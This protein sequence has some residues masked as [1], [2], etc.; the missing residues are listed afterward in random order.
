ML[1]KKFGDK[2]GKNLMDAAKKSGKNAAM[3]AS[4]SVVQKTAEV[5]EI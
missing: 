5:Q 1:Q 3:T 2:Y 4:K